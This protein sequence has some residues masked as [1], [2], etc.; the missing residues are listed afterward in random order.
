MMMVGDTETRFKQHLAHLLHL[1][2][3]ETAIEAWRLAFALAGQVPPN[4]KLDP[5]IVIPFSERPPVVVA[6][7]RWIS[8]RAAAVPVSVHD[9]SMRRRCDISY[10]VSG[11]LAAAMLDEASQHLNPWR[12]MPH[13]WVLDAAA[14]MVGDEPPPGIS[15]VEQLTQEQQAAAAL[16]ASET[17]CAVPAK[18]A[19]P[20]HDGSDWITAAKFTSLM[21]RF[22][23]VAE[24]DVP[25]KS[26]GRQSVHDLRSS[27]I[28]QA[29]KELGHE[30]DSLPPN[31]EGRREG[32]RSV[33]KK[34][35]FQI[36]KTAF[37]PGN[38]DKGFNHSWEK[39]LRDNDLR[40]RVD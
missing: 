6:A 20:V 40:Y 14:L 4:P 37:G 31:E 27:V 9:E 23:P 13:I 7:L 39:M 8:D 33:V 29:I 1:L 34:R 2:K 16:I 17:D 38:L 11:E 18:W 36:N 35:A 26:K 12:A 5:P 30:P 22:G 24:P 10:Y 15:H 19:D 32:V 28:L 21:E 25:A 3:P